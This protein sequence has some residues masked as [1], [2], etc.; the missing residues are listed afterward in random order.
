MKK[1]K[2]TCGR[3]MTVEPLFLATT[4]KGV[5]IVVSNVPVDCCPKC[6]LLYGTSRPSEAVEAQMEVL[7]EEAYQKGVTE[8]EY[9]PN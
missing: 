4:Y 2:C 5:T 8:I 7:L 9:K 1:S 3:E 6:D